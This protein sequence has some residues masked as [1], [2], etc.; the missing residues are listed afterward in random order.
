M[1]VN[2][3]LRHFK[4]IACVGIIATLTAGCSEQGIKT[5]QDIGGVLGETSSPLTN[6]EVIAG[7][8]EALS[9]GTNK[10]TTSAAKPDGFFKNALLFIPFPPEAQAVKTKA[11]ALGLHSQVD[12]FELTL[13]RAA[14]EACKTA[15]PVFIE[16]IKEMTIQDG[17]DILKGPDNAATEYL[18][19]KTTAKLMA[20]FR[21][22]IQKAVDKVELTSY[23]QPLITAYNTA[24]ILTGTQTVNPDLTGYVTEKA[25]SGLF[26]LIAQEE[27]NIRQNPAA[28]VTEL[29]KKVFG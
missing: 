19:E 7:L 24:T 28:R 17:F 2:S 20:D 26:K 15:A 5:L 1:Q 8:R 16:A 23:W 25:T 29:L 22:I 6:A 27:K 21:P 12:K 3:F 11:L 10:G 9:Q 14:E 18:K 13:N 4:K